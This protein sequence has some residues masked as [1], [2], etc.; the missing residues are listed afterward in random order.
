VRE[1][2]VQM[3]HAILDA[4]R[5]ARGWTWADLGRAVALSP[6]TRQKVANG[7]AVSIRTVRRIARV[8]RVSVRSLLAVGDGTGA[9]D[10]QEPPNDGEV[11]RV[12]R[13]AFLHG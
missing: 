1:Q 7:E 8:L 4:A 10:K 5:L 9:A 13:E 2:P 3:N 11:I 6:P 12:G